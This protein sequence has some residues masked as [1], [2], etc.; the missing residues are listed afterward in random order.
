[1]SLLRSKKRLAKL[2]NQESHTRNATPPFKTSNV[3]AQHAKQY[4]KHKRK[5]LACQKV[6]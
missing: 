2:S 1:M 4:K 6:K 3:Q 5:K